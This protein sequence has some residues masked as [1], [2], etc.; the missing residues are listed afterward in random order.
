MLALERTPISI[1]F[2]L[3]VGQWDFAETM[4]VVNL[5]CFEMQA[6]GGSCLSDHCCRIDTLFSVWFEGLD[7]QT[8]PLMLKASF[9]IAVCVQ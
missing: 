2:I 7:F 8:L 4:L 9:I 5:Q 1:H 6:V 3:Q